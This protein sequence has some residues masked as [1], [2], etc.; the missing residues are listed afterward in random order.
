MSWTRTDEENWLYILKARWDETG[1]S[2]I[3]PPLRSIVLGNTTGVG[4]TSRA[5][6]KN[7]PLYNLKWYY[8]QKYQPM[9]PA[10]N[11]G[12]YTYAAITGLPDI[13]SNGF[14]RTVHAGDTSTGLFRMSWVQ[15]MNRKGGR[16]IMSEIVN[17]SFTNNANGSWDEFVNFWLYDYPSTSFFSIVAYAWNGAKTS[18]SSHAAPDH[19]EII[20]VLKAKTIRPLRVEGEGAWVPGPGQASPYLGTFPIG[21]LDDTITDN[22]DWPWIALT[23]VSTT[24]DVSLRDFRYEHLNINSAIDG[25]PGVLEDLTNR[26]K[27]PDL[28]SAQ[29]EEYV[30][31]KYERYSQWLQ[32][33]MEVPKEFRVR[34][35]A[36]PIFDMSKLSSMAMPSDTDTTTATG[37]L[38]TTGGSSY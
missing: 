36:S 4:P 1:A 11:Y 34:C 3:V 14:L 25:F 32:D 22:M 29:S 12:L 33:T 16:A 26:Y 6:H 2:A 38:G 10:Y 15:N 13:D 35:Q 28:I 19:G 8:E 27:T 5:D 17:S 30:N 37:T 7:W 23:A 31:K 24:K 21:S 9:D 20:E 18:A